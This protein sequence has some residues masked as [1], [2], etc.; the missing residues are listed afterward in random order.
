MSHKQELMDA[1]NHLITVWAP[2]EER[3]GE[4]DW[5]SYLEKEQGRLA[6]K[7]ISTEIV[8]TTT[9]RAHKR[10]GERQEVPLY[11]LKQL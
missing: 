1:R 5:L 10:T 3:V 8:H 6:A 11:A 7:G 4:I 9:I 2:G